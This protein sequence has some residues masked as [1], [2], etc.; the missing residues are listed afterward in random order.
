[1]SL[2]FLLI[3]FTLKSCNFHVLFEFS[4]V[5]STDNTRIGTHFEIWSES[6]CASR[7]FLIFVVFLSTVFYYFSFKLPLSHYG[8]ALATN[9]L[10]TPI[11]SQ[12]YNHTS[13]SENWIE[14]ISSISTSDWYIGESL[15]WHI[16]LSADSPQLV[17]HKLPMNPFFIIRLRSSSSIPLIRS[18]LCPL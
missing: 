2:I 8:E 10:H 3:L 4:R 16:T 1:M 6:V 14:I 9:H 5:L 12:S 15:H 7:S 13:R 18:I 11:Y 17:N